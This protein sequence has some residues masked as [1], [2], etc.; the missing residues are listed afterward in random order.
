MNKPDFYVNDDY[1]GLSFNGGGFYYGYEESVCT[2][3]GEKTGSGS[4]YCDVCEDA[5]REWCFS[6][7]F[8]SVDIIIPFSKL[9]CKDMFDVVDCLN[10]GIGWVLAKYRLIEK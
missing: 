3:C 6:A 5:D 1:A 10:T 7:K 4:E 2:S 8:D 9:K